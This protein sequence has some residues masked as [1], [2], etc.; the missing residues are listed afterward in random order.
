MSIQEPELVIFDF[1]DT[2]TIPYEVPIL[3]KIENAILDYNNNVIAIKCE[4]VILKPCS[5]AISALQHI[6]LNYPNIKIAIASTAYT[7]FSEECTKESINLFND[8]M[9]VIC[10]QNFVQM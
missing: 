10:L 4:N 3:P 2:L 6:Y 5:Q 9:S 7:E 1:H 8:Q